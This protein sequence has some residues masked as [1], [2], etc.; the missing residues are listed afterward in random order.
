MSGGI[1]VAPKG[2]MIRATLEDFI[3]A[4]LLRRGYQ[5]V[6]SPHIGRVEMY[7]T[8]GHFSVLSRFAVRTDLRPYCRTARRL[9]DSLPQPRE[10]EP[11]PPTPDDERRLLEAA[12]V[13]GFDEKDFPINGTNDQKREVLRRWEKQQERLLLKPMNCPHHV[14]MYKAMPRSYRDLPVRLASVGTVY[15]YEQSGELKRTAASSRTD[16]G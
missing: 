14:Q 11:A 13:L 15:R 8:S 2:T 12:R 7:E 5:P 3:K 9:L 1:V 16:S 4:E 6:Y 10:A